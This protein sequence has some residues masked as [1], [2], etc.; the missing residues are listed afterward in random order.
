M[1]RALDKLR[2]VKL[3]GRF[4]KCEF[5]KG[6]VDYLGFEVS[7]DGIRNSPEKVKA[8]LD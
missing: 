8:I 4:H 5:L 7:K 2:R 1:K 6:K 3:F